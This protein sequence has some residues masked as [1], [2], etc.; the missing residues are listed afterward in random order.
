M[1]TMSDSIVGLVFIFLLSTQLFCVQGQET[2]TLMGTVLDENRQ[3]IRN[4]T[5]KV[6]GAGY[7]RDLV[8]DSSG[9]FQLLVNREGDYSVL[10]ICDRSDTPGVDYVPALWKTYL[11]LGSMATF[12]FSLEKGASLYFDGEIRFVESSKPADYYKFTVTHPDGEPLSG[13]HSVYTYGSDTDLVRTLGFSEELIVIPAD[14]E[15]AI[16]VD[17]RISSAKI[18]HEFAIKGEP[19]YLRLSQ[20]EKSHM[21]SMEQTL[22]FNV[23]R[24]KQTWDSAFYILK[25]AEHIGFT[26]SAEKQDLL[27]AYALIDDS[28]LSIK[29]KA[30]EETFGKL[31]NAY[32]LISR[33]TERLQGLFLMS[34]LSPFLLM[35]IFA[36]IASSSAYLITERRKRI[37]MFSQETKKFSI[38]INL[39]I[40][41]LFYSIL[42]LTFYFANPGCRLMGQSAFFAAAILALIVGQSAVAA[43]PRAFTEKRSE[44]RSIQFGSAV[45]IAFSM[46][47]RNLRRRKLRTMLSLANIIVLVFAFV[48]FT[49]I[50]AGS[51]LVTRSLRPSIPQHAILI[52]DKLEG[53]EDPFLPLPSSLLT[54]LK[55]QPSITTISPKSENI[56]EMGGLGSLYT[57]SGGEF[58]I[59]GIVGIV[60]S[61]EVNF[62]HVNQAIASGDYLRDDDPKG[63][64]ISS[65]LSESLDLDVGDKL[66][67]F[68][69]E[70]T[71]RGFFDKET[72]EN[73]RDVDGSLWIPRRI[74]PGDASDASDG[75]AIVP[76][77]GD[78]V[79]IVNYNVSFSLPRVVMSR[80]NVQLKNPSFQEYS[81]FA[82]MVVLSREYRVY[83]SHPDSLHLQYVGSYVEERGTGLI[84]FL[85]ILVMLNIS[86]MTLGSVIERKDEIASLS[87]VGLNP[88]HIS[89]LFVAEA[90]VIGFIGGGLG[91]LLGILGCRTA[92]TIWFGPLQVQEKASAEWG[93]ISLL[94]STFTAIVASVIPVLKASTMIT[95]SLLR[96]WI[97]SK[98]VEPRDRDQQVLDLP[99]K[100]MSRELEP[101]MGFI[102]KRIRE[103]S[104]TGYATDISLK[105][106]ETDRGRLRRL[107]FR[108]N[109]PGVSSTNELL[110]QRAEGK[111]F[112]EAKLLCTPSMRAKNAIRNTATLVRNLILEWNA[113]K[114][115]V[116]TPFDPY[117]GQLYTL[118]NAYTPTTLYVMT[119]ESDIGE[120]LELLKRAL[121]V[122]GLRPPRIVISRVEVLDIRQIMETAEELVSRADVICI[123][124][125]PAELST[126]LAMNAAKQKKITCYVV[127]RRPE[128]DRI[129]SPY[130]NSEIVTVP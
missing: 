9:S 109:Q 88:T 21:D 40:S 110:I 93:L 98:E 38:S 2:A 19:G 83:V 77:S 20:G 39:L 90:A 101:F 36:F 5:V 65:S 15:V 24:T 103:T 49:S 30:Y 3:P 117:L 95:P 82:R 13:K 71:I 4:A 105:E 47:C 12:T 1:A 6:L 33:T 66:Y 116:A 56:P 62:T 114:F 17:A 48:T 81:E 106:E 123:S 126:A 70:F 35:P 23:E 118:V 130:E 92:L 14:T 111:D 42:I 84:P 108:Y 16:R 37:E 22:A 121:V 78:E 41:I 99:V 112:F 96:K 11:E 74:I 31:R 43:S 85:M 124:G 64:L 104:R 32:S 75:E 125:E 100:F 44:S 69:K 34:S 29:R 122:R 54:W 73:L 97:T 79:M 28:L 52:R 72:T 51:G 46:A 76:C 58:L 119:T 55:N 8:T 53:S 10:A 63:V 89:A 120:K 25:D 50:S 68:D 127:D 57:R 86:A 94:L 59:R 45:I 102:Q 87:S 60:P 67:G 27:H 115:E 113:I 91:Y 61:V 7:V 26:V 128:Q 80:V 18:H 107:M 129:R